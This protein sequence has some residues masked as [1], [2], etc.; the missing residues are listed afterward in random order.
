M[1]VE[2]NAML[3]L[4]LALFAPFIFVIFGCILARQAD[5]INLSQDGVCP[6]CKHSIKKGE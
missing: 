5:R 3:L 6:T 1:A 2:V 4:F